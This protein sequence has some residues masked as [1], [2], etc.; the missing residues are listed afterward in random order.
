MIYTF[1]NYEIDALTNRIA[2]RVCKE[3][4]EL[5]P[6]AHNYIQSICHDEISQIIKKGDKNE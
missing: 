6:E 5:P 2:Q 4:P 1:N 3:M